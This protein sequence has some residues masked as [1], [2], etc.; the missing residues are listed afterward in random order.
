M[1]YCWIITK[2]HIDTTKKGKNKESWN[3]NLN[4]RPNTTHQHGHAELRKRERS[5]FKYSTPEQLSL[6]QK[7]FSSTER[8]YLRNTPSI[9][10]S[11]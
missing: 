7:R 11:T 5:A 8:R 10:L 3:D 9:F 1:S 2:D 4:I 6:A